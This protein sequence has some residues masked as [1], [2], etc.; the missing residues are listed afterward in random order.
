MFI[1][2]KHII[3]S[4]FFVTVSFILTSMNKRSKRLDLLLQLPNMFMKREPLFYS[5]RC[6]FCY[7]FIKQ[8][9]RR[10]VSN[11]RLQPKEDLKLQSMQKKGNSTASS[12]DAVK[13]NKLHSPVVKKISEKTINLSLGGLVKVLPSSRRWTDGSVSWASL[14]PSLSK[15]GKVLFLS[16]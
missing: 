5:H 8:V 15:H 14:P 7:I 10:S 16:R 13:S 12:E 4:F 1:A 9:P 11:E 3:F 6:S 2:L